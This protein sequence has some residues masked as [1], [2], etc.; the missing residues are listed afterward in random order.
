M[1][2]SHFA[3]VSDWMDNGSIN[4]FL[5]GNPDVN[6][7]DLVRLSSEFSLR[8][9]RLTD[10]QICD[11]AEGRCWDWSI[12]APVEVTVRG[13]VSAEGDGLNDPNCGDL[14]V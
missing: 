11:P 9:E 7:S 13:E 4:E 14:P 5:K 3:M 8:F 1:S 2:E 10:E 12:S 6:R